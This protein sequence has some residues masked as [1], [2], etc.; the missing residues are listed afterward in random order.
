[1]KTRRRFDKQFKLEVVHRSMGD[2]SLKQ[3]ADELS[4]HPSVI[5]RWRQEYSKAGHE[6][7]FPGN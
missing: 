6:L 3:L 1:M 7:S 4:I 2:I 5:D